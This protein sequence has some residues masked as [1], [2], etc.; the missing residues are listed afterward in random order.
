MIR[1]QITKDWSGYQYDR[2]IKRILNQCQ[3]K[4]SEDNYELIKKYDHQMT[5]DMLSKAVRQKSLQSLYTISC[6]FI[7]GKDWKDVKREDID[8]CCYQIAQTYCDAKGLETH[9]SYDKKKDM[10]IFFRWFKTG[11]RVKRSQNEPEVYELQGIKMGKVKDRIAREDLFTQKDIE[12]LLAVCNNSNRNKALIDVHSEAGTRPG[13]LISMRIKDVVFDEYGGKIKVEGKTIARQIR[14]IRSVPNLLR[15]LEDHP[16]KDEPDHPLWIQLG[17]INYGEAMTYASIRQMLYTVNKRA[18]TGK[19]ATAL[20]HFRHSEATDS[21]NFMTEAQMRKRHGWSP[22]SKMPSRYVHM[23]DSDVEN[24]ILER[25]GIKKKENKVSNTPRKCQFCDM[26]NSHDAE[27]CVKCSKPLD[28]LQAEKMALENQ[29][30]NEDLTN[31]VK[32]LMKKVEKLEREKFDK[33][34]PSET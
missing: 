21:A 3:E 1:K 17:K 34:F 9:G 16:F 30:G 2:N 4:L 22:S 6:N 28:S 14:I 27:I 31:L 23:I 8:E 26:F 18:K 10:R 12:K 32:E 11:S 20:N 29:K 25:H 33:T 24:A 5:R 7:S 19:R 15:Y 13:E